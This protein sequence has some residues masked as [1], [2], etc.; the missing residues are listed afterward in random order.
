LRAALGWTQRQ[1]AVELR[2]S[3]RTLIRHEQGQ[4]LRPWMRLSL[5]QRLREVESEHEQQLFA[6]LSGV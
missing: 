1:A 6:H 3:R 4:H 2:I 5:L